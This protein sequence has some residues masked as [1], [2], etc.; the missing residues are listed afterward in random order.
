MEEAERQASRDGAALVN[1]MHQLLKAAY[2]QTDPDAQHTAHVSITCDMR[3]AVAWIHWRQV[4]NEGNITYEMER[5]AQSF[6]NDGESMQNVKEIIKNRTEDAMGPRLEIIRGAIEVLTE[7]LDAEI[8]VVPV[9]A[10]QIV[11]PQHLATRSV[12]STVPDSQARKRSRFD[13]AIDEG[14]Q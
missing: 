1:S 11:P 10:Q 8:S 12:G 6:C 3:T 14:L 2:P 13:A 9:I 5:L 4:D 7:K